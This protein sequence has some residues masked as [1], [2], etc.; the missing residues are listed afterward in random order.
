M[1]K[2]LSIII[3]AAFGAVACA[4]SL[5]VTCGAVTYSFNSAQTG[6]MEYSDGSSLTIQGKEFS[7]P[8]I[9]V[10]KVGENA[11]ADNLVKVTYDGD[12][13]T[14]TVSG[15]VASYV[16][17]ICDGAYVTVVQSGDVS[18][19]TCGEITYRLSG[20]SADGAFRL[21]GSYKASVELDNVNL[22][23]RRG[24][25]IDIQNGKRIA[26]RVSEGTVNVLADAAGGSQKGCINCKG[27][28]EFK[29]KGALTVTGNTAHGIYAKEYI[30]LKNSRIT[31]D[32]A[33]KDGLNCNQYFK[34]ESGSLTIS[35]V[36][37]DGIQTSFKDD[38]DREDEDTGSVSING[39]TLDISVTAVAA[40]AVN[41]DGDFN[42]SGG[43]LNASTSGHGKWDSTAMKTKAAACISADGTVNINGGTLDLTS[44]GGG[45]KGIS[46][47]GVITVN[48][49]NLKILTTGGLYVYRNGTE[50]TN[51]TGNADNIASNNKSSAKGIKCDSEIIINGGNFDITTQGANSEGIESKDNLTINGG[52]IKVRAKDDGI[53]CAFDLS[54]TGGVLDVVSASNDGL[55]SNRNTY[56]SGGV[57]AVFGASGVECG[58]DVGDGYRLYFQGGYILAAAGNNSTP[59]SSTQAY[60][61]PN[62]T[63]TKDTTVSIGT[64]SSTF[65]TFTVPAEYSASSGGRSNA[66]GGGGP[67]GMGGS[68]VLI[69]TPELVSGTS[70]TIKYGNSTATATAKK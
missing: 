31:V 18:D 35:G 37:D 65:Y 33:I 23:S 45:G 70:Y 7:I 50:Y 47:D 46:S 39:G 29:Q 12:N 10:M 14:V 60:V 40:K 54:I 52:N 32:G 36:G 15:N 3:M 43:T 38:A 11:Q 5:D 4:Q 58:I 51:Y 69:S 2:T 6:V 16:D 13:A 27:H 48:D 64:S 17:I 59:S 66:P 24:A 8:D 1:K 21:D 53:N 22:K 9:T 61:A 57:V 42:M 26:M 28:L 55:D 63:L 44:T 25:A 49:G 41:A 19:D 20:A 34:M 56:I 67:G 30:E 62:I 68:K